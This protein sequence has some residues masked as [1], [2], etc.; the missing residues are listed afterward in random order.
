MLDHVVEFYK[1][2]PEIAEL[3][4]MQ[5]KLMQKDFDLMD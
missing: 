1:T 4:K 5:G 2:Y 3:D